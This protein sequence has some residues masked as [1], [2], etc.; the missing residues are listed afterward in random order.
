MALLIHCTCTCICL[1]ARASCPDFF[2][3]CSW[4]TCCAPLGLNSLYQ[5]TMPLGDGFHYAELPSPFV[6]IL[7]WVM[8]VGSRGPRN[9]LPSNGNG[10]NLCRSSLIDLPI[11][12]AHQMLTEL[13]SPFSWHSELHQASWQATHRCYSSNDEHQRRLNSCPLTTLASIL[14]PKNPLLPFLWTPPLVS[15]MCGL[16]QP[17]WFMR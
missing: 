1:G 12:V 17:Y 2:G 13:I 11:N 15:P 16:Q 10:L 3:W 8:A 9:G 4:Q 7:P 14:S 5:R 6:S